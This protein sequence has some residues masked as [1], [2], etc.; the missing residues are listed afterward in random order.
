MFYLV[1]H[2]FSLITGSAAGFTSAGS[3][4]APSL[5]PVSP[6]TDLPS[7]VAYLASSSVFLLS[8]FLAP[9]LLLLL[10]FL[11][12]VDLDVNYLLK[13]FSI[14]LKTRMI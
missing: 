12:L 10:D 11:D 5:L 4:S 6:P 7:S 8:S 2:P 3:P 9:D 1:N 13:F 14:I